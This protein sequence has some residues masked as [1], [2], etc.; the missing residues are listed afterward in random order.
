MASVDLEEW[1]T[2]C[3]LD[4]TKLNSNKSNIFGAVTADAVFSEFSLEKLITGVKIIESAKHRLKKRV[5][6]I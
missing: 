3:D 1:Q 4:R 6:L 2:G 5:N